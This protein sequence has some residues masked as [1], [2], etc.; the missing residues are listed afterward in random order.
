M[1]MAYLNFSE[2][3]EATLA[4]VALL[5]APVEETASLSALEWSVVALARRDRLS[6]INKPGRVAMAM[7][8]LFGSKHNPSLTDEKLEALR[9]ISV[10]AWHRGYA[11]HSSDVRAFR[12]AGY[13][14]AQYELVQASIGR[15]RNARNQRVH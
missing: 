10:L 12:D 15:A 9:R 6:S 7:A 8:V 3:H 14:P 5:R 11:L 13:S 1:S 4:P 2:P